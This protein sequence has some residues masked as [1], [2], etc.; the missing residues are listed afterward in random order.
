MLRTLTRPSR[1][2][3][4]YR[5]ASPAQVAADVTGEESKYPPPFCRATDC[6]ESATAGC[7]GYCAHCWQERQARAQLY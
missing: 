1:V 4:P 6:A 2:H 3:G 5:F 7:G